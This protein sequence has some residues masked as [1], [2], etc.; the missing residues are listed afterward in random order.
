MSGPLPHAAEV[1]REEGARAAREELSKDIY[2]RS[3]PSLIEII[4]T[5]VMDWIEELTRRIGDS[6]PGGWWALGALLAVLA[7]LLVAL[8]VHTRPARR[9]RRRGAQVDQDTPLSASGHRALAERHAEAGAYAEAIVERLRA[10]SRELEDRAIVL[11]RA[12]RTA[13]ELATEASPAL[14]DERGALRAAADVFNDVRYGERV[15]TADSYAVLRDL[16][17]RIQTARPHHGREVTR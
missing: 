10:I 9:A 15:A 5:R 7:V 8:L 1:S 12:G 17:E 11:P 13:T 4:Y 14:P 6:V 16:D 2:Q 3:E